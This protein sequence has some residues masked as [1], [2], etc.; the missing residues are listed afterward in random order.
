MID[1]PN[2][3]QHLQNLSTGSTYYQRQ[4][5]D[6]NI[7]EKAVAQAA[8]ALGIQSGLHYESQKIYAVL[9]KHA[10]A[11]DKVFN[12]G[13]LLYQNNILP[14]VIV[15][16]SNTV[17]ISNTGDTLRIAGKTYRIIRQVKFVTAQPTWRN[18]LWMSYPKPELPNKI[19][20][21]KTDEERAA[22]QV[23]V[24]NGWNQGIKQA[25]T[26]YGIN[27]HRLVR[28]YNGMVLYKSLLL[29]NMVSPFYVTKKNYGV[30]GTGS[31]IAV[32]DQSLSITTKPE[33]Q[34]HSKLWNPVVRTKNKNGKTN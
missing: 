13:I 5:S 4:F 24:T 12:F 32:D 2:T 19:L 16:A 15:K 14:P 33:L 25:M 7:R 23:A 17:H 29:Q 3:L 30:T 9:T 10:S 22:W 6:S 31:H 11:M 18:Y 34:L 1:Q 20:L 8:Q 21:P 27:L 26:I 28:D